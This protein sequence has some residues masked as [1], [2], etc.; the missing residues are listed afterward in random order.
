LRYLRKQKVIKNR[1][2][3]IIDLYSN[4][5]PPFLQIHTR[6]LIFKI[7]KIDEMISEILSCWEL[8]RPSCIQFITSLHARVYIFHLTYNFVLFAYYL[9]LFAKSLKERINQTFSLI[10]WPKILSLCSIKKLVD[11]ILKE[12]ATDPYCQ[13]IWYVL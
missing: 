4:F 12:K 3:N 7:F 13:L 10:N 2:F 9:I 5:R 8:L 6:D 11:I 1:K